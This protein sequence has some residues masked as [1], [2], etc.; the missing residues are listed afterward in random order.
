MER[1]NPDDA[2]NL[3]QEGE[4]LVQIANCTAVKGGPTTKP[5]GRD[6]LKFVFKAKDVNGKTALI[7]FL[8]M[9]V[10][11]IKKIFQ[12]FGLDM[13]QFD[14]G[15]VPA[16]YYVSNKDK[17]G[18]VIIKTK[19]SDNPKYDDSSVISAFLKHYSLSGIP[20]AE[21]E[22]EANDINDDIPF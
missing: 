1:F 18:K 14:T 22:I 16:S 12:C 13:D 9:E 19:R 15:Y 21:G 2:T 3:L 20:H 6:M 17:T 5:P 10:W 7:N 4:A 8:A 11:Q